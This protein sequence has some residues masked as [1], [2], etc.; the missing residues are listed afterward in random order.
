MRKKGGEKFRNLLF[1]RFYSFFSASEEVLIEILNL[2]SSMNEVMGGGVLEIMGRGVQTMMEKMGI[3][4]TLWKKLIYHARRRKKRE[5]SR[6]HESF[7]KSSF[8][9]L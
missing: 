4:F 9:N 2:L 5:K 1:P 3:I 6:N 7:E 8:Y